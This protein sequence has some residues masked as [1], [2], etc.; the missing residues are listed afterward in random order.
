[1]PKATDKAAT[2]ADDTP[3]TVAEKLDYLLSLPENRGRPEF[4]QDK[5]AEHLEKVTGRTRH[6]GYISGILHGKIQNP[7]PGD[8]QVLAKKLGVDPDY[9]SDDEVTEAV[10][11]E[12]TLL[13]TLRDGGLLEQ[14]LRLLPQVAA[15]D[16]PKVLR[17][18]RE[19]IANRTQDEAS[20][21]TDSSEE[22]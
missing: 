17:F 2:P 5:L 12:I 18:T 20:K 15:D 11:E 3:K 7:H 22:S 14:L 21:P 9:F 6:R 4:T 1:M 16:I 19:L 8:L 13:T 10:I